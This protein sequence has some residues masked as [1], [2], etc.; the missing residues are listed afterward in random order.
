MTSVI[1]WPKRADAAI[2]KMTMLRRLGRNAEA[3]QLR[4]LLEQM[5]T[6]LSE[7]SEKSASFMNDSFAD[8]L[9]FFI[10]ELL[11]TLKKEASSKP[12][13][14]AGDENATG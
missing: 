3:E 1:T 11:L 6:Y 12:V 13:E 9:V 7:A 10:N 8:K 5:E 4:P 14:Q 2:N